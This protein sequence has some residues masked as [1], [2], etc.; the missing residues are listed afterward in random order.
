M[1][2]VVVAVAG[3]VDLAGQWSS[4]WERVNQ[5]G[6]DRLSQLMTWVGIILVISAVVGWAW[7]KRHG[8]GGGGSQAVMWAAGIGAFL[9]AP[10][11]VIPIVL[12]LVDLLANL[13]LRLLS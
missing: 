11:V 10:Q 6:W 5:G 3:S 4:F 8:G 13:V 9:S 7:K 12:T 2:A 1:D